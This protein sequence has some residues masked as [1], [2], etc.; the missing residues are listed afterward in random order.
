MHVESDQEVQGHVEATVN[1][2]VSGYAGPYLSTAASATGA[3]ATAGTCCAETTGSSLQTIQ[4]SAVVAADAQTQLTGSADSVSV[5]SSA[6]G[7][8]TGWEQINGSVQSWTGQVNS[9]LTSASNSGYLGTV[10]GNTGLSSAAVANNVTGDIDTSSTDIGVGQETYGPATNAVV[11]VSI[12]S[13]AD[14]QGLASGVGNNVDVQA[15]ASDAGMN[16]TQR[17]DAPLNAY[18]DLDVANWSGDASAT[19]YGVGNSVVLSNGGPSVALWT[20]QASNGDVDVSAGFTGGAG[21]YAYTSATAIGNAV[22]GYACD[23]CGGA[24]TATNRQIGSARVQA[25]STTVM[26]RAQ[27]V[28]ADASAI[29]NSATY[30]VVG[31]G[32]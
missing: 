13:G 7:N 27:A 6:V 19:A 8:T 23:T 28:A 5:D 15:V 20:D 12:G 10:Y 2:Q 30:R 4:S 22:S 31:S 32:N 3:S 26:G 16:V 14:I 18:T 21:G 29:G 25:N 9:G 24:I 17:N 11:D 1:A